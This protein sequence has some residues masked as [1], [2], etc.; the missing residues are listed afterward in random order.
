MNIKK[1][2]KKTYYSLPSPL[3][4]IQGEASSILFKLA[5]LA[6]LFLPIS[7]HAAA[8]KHM[9]PAINTPKVE[10]FDPGDLELFSSMGYAN[11]FIYDFDFG[12]RYSFSENLKM[13]VT[14]LHAD[15]LIGGFQY[16]F[17]ENKLFGLAS[18]LNYL[19]NNNTPTDIAEYP[20]TREIK[21]SPYLAT[22]LQL[23]FVR[24]NFGAGSGEYVGSQFVSGMFGSIELGSQRTALIVEHDGRNMNVGFKFTLSNNSNFHFSATEFPIQDTNPEYEDQPTRYLTTGFSIKKN[25]WNFYSDKII[26]YERQRAAMDL[27]RK[28]MKLLIL[29]YQKELQ[30]LKD[31]QEYILHNYKEFQDEAE[32]RLD[33][34]T[35]NERVSKRTSKDETTPPKKDTLPSKLKDAD[36]VFELYNSAFEAYLA[37]DYQ[38]AV[39]NLTKAILIE[40][41]VADLYIKLG[42]IYYE[43][44]LE[45]LAMQTWQEALRLEP[46]N[47]DLL[48]IFSE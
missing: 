4:M 38:T 47:P 39:S 19:T 34:D 15:Q 8:Y 5:L 25:I 43:M 12:V 21:F 30:N 46:D 27:M 6:M 18:G 41:N 23:G 13:G 11:E 16:T 44:G 35:N 1:C 26:E 20:S 31:T 9:A 28:E 48:P 7:L 3:A 45:D 40:P 14:L 10:L 42:T 32:K 2:V 37:N 24:L 22:K 29:D 17:F 36:K 33:T